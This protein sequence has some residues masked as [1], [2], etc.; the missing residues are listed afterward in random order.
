MGMLVGV[1]V[2]A[3]LYDLI[4]RLILMGLRW[5]NRT[6]LINLYIEKFVPKK[7]SKEKKRPEIHLPFKMKKA[8]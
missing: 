6:D 2:F 5:R 7:E 1:P 8:K 3:V 4:C